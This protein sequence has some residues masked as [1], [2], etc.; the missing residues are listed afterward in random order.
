MRI[1]ILQFLN[2][3]LRISNVLADLLAVGLVLIVIQQHIQSADHDQ[4]IFQGHFITHRDTSFPGHDT[5]V[6]R[7]L[8]TGIRSFAALRMTGRR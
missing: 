7:E 1:L 6:G 3:G 8:A 5:T 4:K 2:N